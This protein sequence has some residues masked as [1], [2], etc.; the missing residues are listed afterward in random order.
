MMHHVYRMYDST[1][2]LLYIGQSVSLA[3]RLGGH[4]SGSEWWPDVRTIK[5]EPHADSLAARSAEA[6]A[7]A[8]ERP[9]YNVSGL[10][11]RPV[12]REQRNYLAGRRI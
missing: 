11:S 2:R 1:G 7:I 8:T 12:S 9:A 4:R 5:V 3:E 6:R 10:V